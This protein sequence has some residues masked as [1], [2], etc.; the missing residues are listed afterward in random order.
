[1]YSASILFVLSAL[2]VYFTNAGPLTERRK[3]FHTFS[4]EQDAVCPPGVW[5]CSTGKRSLSGKPFSRTQDSASKST[6]PPG[7]WTCSTGKRSHIPDR[8]FPAIVIT[9]QDNNEANGSRDPANTSRRIWTSRKN[10]MLKRM[11]K[12]RTST[13]K[14]FQASKVVCP[15]LQAFG[16][17]RLENDKRGKKKYTAK[18]TWRFSR[19][20]AMK[21]L[22]PRSVWDRVCIRNFVRMKHF[23][24]VQTRDVDN[25]T[26]DYDQELHDYKKNRE[27]FYQE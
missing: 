5:T 15:P 26:V 2:Q 20:Q 18:V 7:V 17:V 3:L 8:Q 13:I 6:C 10:K 9:V 4:S 1:M 21:P 19:R 23:T 16:H 27:W 25:V 24:F 12:K 11:V 14:A 22:L